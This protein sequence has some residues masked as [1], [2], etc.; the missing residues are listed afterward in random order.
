[1]IDVHGSDGYCDELRNHR[2]EFAGTRQRVL[3]VWVVVTAIGL[4]LLATGRTTMAAFLGVMPMTLLTI[5]LVGNEWM[6]R[7]T[8][9]KIATEC[10]DEPEPSD[11]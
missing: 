10:P 11:L 7:R 2:D 6:L 1:M 9:R 8:T 3:I 5:I 4:A